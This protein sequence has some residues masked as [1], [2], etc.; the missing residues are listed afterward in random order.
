MSI[1]NQG[2]I[3]SMDANPFRIPLYVCPVSLSVCLSVCMYIS[4][5][6]Y[7]WLT[8][9]N[10]YSV[11]VPVYLPVYLSVCLHIYFHTVHGCLSVCLS[12]YPSAWLCAC[13]CMSVSPY[14]C[15]DWLTVSCCFQG[16][17]ETIFDC[18]F[19]PEDPDLLAT[20]SFDGTI[21]VWDIRTLKAV[22][23]HPHASSSSCILMHPH[24]PP[25]PSSP[26]L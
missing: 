21:K 26:L 18:K 25:L 13:L 17:I 12:T 2:T 14:L 19:S 15:I 3:W 16:H 4:L 8:V 9:T 10:Y 24:A 22:S 11:W 7:V 1:K 20:A 6:L 23:P 5:S